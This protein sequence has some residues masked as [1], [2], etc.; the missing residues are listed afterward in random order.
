LAASDLGN[1]TWR[2][3]FKAAID[4]NWGVYSQ[5]S[6]GEGPIPTKIAFDTLASS[7][8]VGAARESGPDMHEGMDDLF[9]IN[10]RKYYKEATFS[11]DVQV[12][13]PA[14]AITGTI[15]FMACDNSRCIFPDPLRFSIVPATG[16]AQVGDQPA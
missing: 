6:F 10:V 16:L 8:P 14:Q 13:D 3:D 11:Q 9:G 15:E 1:G 12:Q 4:E 5:E 2:L 7:A